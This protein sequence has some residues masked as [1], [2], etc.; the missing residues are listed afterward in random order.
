[1][2]VDRL[3]GSGAELIFATTT[4][5]PEGKVSPHRDVEDPARYNAVAARADHVCRVVCG[6]P[7]WVKGGDEF[8][9]D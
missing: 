3:K 7:R 5:V 9:R 6:L 4:P 2:I 8:G 1:M